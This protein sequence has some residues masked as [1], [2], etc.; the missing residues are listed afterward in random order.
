MRRPPHLHKRRGRDG[1]EAKAEEEEREEEEEKERGR[2]EDRKREEEEKEEKQIEERTS[3]SESGTGGEK[4][5]EAEGEREIHEEKVEVTPPVMDGECEERSLNGRLSSEEEEEE[6][7]EDIIEEEEGEA[8]EEYETGDGDYMEMRSTVLVP[9]ASAEET[10]EVGS[11][12]EESPDADLPLD[13][14]DTFGFL[15]MMDSSTY[16]PNNEFSVEPPCYED[17]EYEDSSWYD[18]DV[19]TSISTP[20][21]AQTSP[22]SPVPLHTLTSRPTS[23]PLHTRLSIKSHSLPYKCSPCYPNASSSS[24][25]DEDEVVLSD[26]SDEEDEDEDDDERGEYED[27]FMRSLPNELEFHG[28]AWPASRGEPLPARNNEDT[29]LSGQSEDRVLTA[30]IPPSSGYL[31]MSRVGQSHNSNQTDTSS[32]VSGTQSEGKVIHDEV[33]LP[34][35]SQ[36]IN[37]VDQ[38]QSSPATDTSSLANQLMDILPL[39]QSECSEVQTDSSHDYEEMRV[40]DVESNG[41]TNK[42]MDKETHREE[43]KEEEE[44]EERGEE[45]QRADE[46][47]V[48]HTATAGPDTRTQLDQDS[49]GTHLGPPLPPRDHRNNTQTD[50]N[51]CHGET[52]SDSE[53]EEV[54][55]SDLHPASATAVPSQGETRTSAGEG[56]AS[57]SD[58]SFNVVS[59]EPTGGR[60]QD[61]TYQKEEKEGEE[62][63]EE[64]DGENEGKIETGDADEE[65]S[66]KEEGGQDERVTDEEVEEDGEREKEGEQRVGRNEGEWTEREEED[67][68]KRLPVAKEEE[69]QPDGSER[70]VTD[71]KGPA[72]EIADQRSIGEE[73]EE[74]ETERGEN[75]F[76]MSTGEAGAVSGQVGKEREEVEEGHTEEGHLAPAGHQMAEQLLESQTDHRA[77]EDAE[78]SELLREE[79]EREEEEEQVQNP[80]SEAEQGGERNVGEERKDRESKTDD[81]LASLGQ[82]LGR[83][84]VVSKQ[85]PVRMHQAKAVPVVPPK[86]QQS[87]LTALGLRQQMQ[88]RDTH[89][90]QQK[91]RDAPHTQHTHKQDTKR[92]QQHTP[93]TQTPDTKTLNTLHDDRQHQAQVRHIESPVA[94]EHTDAALH[95]GDT[96][97]PCG[98]EN[99]PPAEH[100]DADPYLPH[101]NQQHPQIETPEQSLDTRAEQHAAQR[102]SETEVGTG[103]D[104]GGTRE[105]GAE[106]K[107]GQGEQKDAEAG[108]D[109]SPDVKK[110]RLSL[111]EGERERRTR[112]REVKRNSG[113]S[114]CFDEAVARATRERERE[115]EH[116]ER[117]KERERGVSVQDEK[118]LK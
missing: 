110:N 30:F 15:D 32:S 87:R 73:K 72:E 28:L 68:E 25:E 50:S 115:R 118:A 49:T 105:Q 17:D 14:Q 9:S 6:E 64:K 56:S 7:E 42:E 20:Q 16:Q 100:R 63:E 48:T 23:L 90:P 53:V 112:D 26:P 3:E 91:D 31:N 102:Q 11:V 4:E 1:G 83:T 84:L 96:T 94:Q 109:A 95:T 43:S 47:W 92:P 51:H 57:E 79:R 76:F 97:Q 33:Q 13:F 59:H 78:K 106:G 54:D 38:S 36:N 61:G 98:P 2:K 5:E 8:E 108:R 80:I 24:D 69:E 81:K 86:P 39:S 65:E 44:R 46:T 12:E 74:N 77:S 62:M 70:A 103:G 99:D 114:M 29:C 117:E 35:S 45:G 82:G 34:I 19:Q 107:D 40:T 89:S 18:H 41:A 52:P 88:S 27:M 101:I 113:I 111:Q 67:E 22:P 58:T 71:Q 37:D 85:V 116:S 93:D 104:E 66:D 75:E 60:W 10:P 55:W 21:K